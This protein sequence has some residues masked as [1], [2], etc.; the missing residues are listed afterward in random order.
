MK[1]A[2][3]REIIWKIPVKDNVIFIYQLI[4]SL[5]N[6]IRYIGITN[7]PSTRLSHHLTEKDKNHKNSWIKNVLNNNGKIQMVIFDY[8]ENLE[9]ALIKEEKYINKYEN[10][11]NLCLRPTQPNTKKCYL[12]D[13]QT[14]KTI[15][16]I[17]VSSAAFFVKIQPS[18]FVGTVILKSRYLFSFEKNFN[19]IINELYVMRIKKGNKILKAISYN[20]AIWLIGC[21]RSMINF[22]LMKQRKSVKGWVIARKDEKFPEYSYG[23]NKKIKCLTD[24]KLFTSIK[25]AAKFYKGD[26]SCITKCC[27]GLRKSHKGKQFI[28]NYENK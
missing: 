9:H 21:S 4:S 16:F 6:V 1:K 12:Y 13:L 22:C 25:E 15:S 20:H 23:N 7:N 10:L 18:S 26:E 14:G 2:V 17:S 24:N 28:Y 27:K 11:T 5:D 3:N 19:T 8:A